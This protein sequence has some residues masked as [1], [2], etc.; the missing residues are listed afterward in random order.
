MKQ[1]TKSRSNSDL[2][3]PFCMA[4]VFCFIGAFGNG[5]L[6]YKSFFQ[7]LSRL[8]EKPIAT[9]TFK[10]K[11]A[12]RKFLDK[13]VWD[14]LRQSSPI[15]NGDTVHTASLAEATIHFNDGNKMELFQN[16]MAQ[17]FYNEEG[18]KASLS[19]GNASL[20]TRSSSNTATLEING[21]SVHLNNGAKLSAQAKA[22]GVFTVEEGVAI[23]TNEKGESKEISSGQAISI[24]EN[25]ELLEEEV[26]FTQ[27]LMQQR[28]IYHNE[29]KA[30]VIFNATSTKYK[31]ITLELYS[32]K[33][34]RNLVEEVPLTAD[35]PT[36]IRLASG[37]YYWQGVYEKTGEDYLVQTQAGRLC[38]VQSLPPHLIAPASF[39]AYNYRK[40]LPL[41]RL[42]WTDAKLAS[43]YKV[44]VSRFSDF[45]TLDINMQTSMTSAIIA[46]LGEGKYYWRVTPYYSVGDLGLG[47]SSNTECFIVE[48]KGELQCP[49]QLLPKD[50][51]TI[52]IK[53]K[54]DITLSWT[55]DMEAQNYTVR[56]ANN[57]AM[58]KP[59]ITAIVE[60][61]MLSIKANKLEEGVWYWTVETCDNEGN[62]SPIC[63]SRSFVVMNGKLSQHTVEPCDNYHVSSI[64][65]S[66]MQWTWKQ[67][68]PLAS[69]TTTL[70]LAHDNAFSDIFMQV[71]VQNNATST[72]GITLP[73]GKYY[74]RLHTVLSSDYTL[75]TLPHCLYVDDLLP[76]AKLIE[77]T[78]R[79]LCEEEKPSVLKWQEVEGATF[80]KV[81]IFDGNKTFLEEVVYDTEIDEYLYTN[82]NFKDRQWY[83]WSVQ[84]FCDEV[85][86]VHSRMI[87]KL[88]S[89]KFFLYRVHP[90]VISSPPQ[91]SIFDRLSVLLEPIVASYD[92]EESL[93][94]SQVLVHKTS[95]SPP[96][97]V[98][99]YPP[100]Q[101]A[102]KI[103]KASKDTVLKVPGGLL[104]GDYEISVKAIT[105]D[106]IDLSTPKE[107]AIRFKVTP[108]LP[109]EP[110][111]F[112]KTEP[113]F[114]DR[115]YIQSHNNARKIYMSWG[116][117]ERATDYFVTIRDSSGKSILV[118]PF[119]AQS[120]WTLDFD[121]LNS[122][123]KQT[124]S[125]GDF[126]WE[127]TA[128]MCVDT[129][130][131]GKLDTLFLTS[132]IAKEHFTTSIK[133]A[134]KPT[135][136][137]IENPYG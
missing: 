115:D 63:D 131:D 88:S 34:M 127:V 50:K 58:L 104:A 60:E 30:S 134:P 80:Y 38:V 109:L 92:T 12:Q 3:V 35:T 9:I 136:K 37:V 51:D 55:G 6:F 132:P 83:S 97:C 85:V 81:A 67:N 117:V 106:G 78:G 5:V 62:L 112:L 43:S 89:D 48:K 45:S 29:G 110:P 126:T 39:Y 19:T 130:K 118:S 57:N 66:D 122:Y 74:W 73:V 124:L 135:P 23:A 53:A 16:S 44:E 1:K 86:G 100:S 22:G 94:F 46:T 41:V 101:K 52:D 79:L 10:Y 111:R 71:P 26:H 113:T 125:S 54:N 28:V 98:Y 82:T 31:A 69:S 114:F 72:K 7:S 137:G 15:Y 56:I 84:A 108:P 128:R 119:I 107:K 116:K 93:S 25:G 17:V 95:V 64:L 20:D 75:D 65:I 91:D 2:L 133:T 99:E 8:D 87:G 103:N 27:P 42:L 14:R 47:V 4:I 11:S 24:S 96:I 68:L 105:N 120:E 129:T 49:K 32:D 40:R 77:P 123:D 21:N 13:V 76:P 121:K 33:Y 90:V 18:V 70:Q 61:N 102:T 36:V 59:K